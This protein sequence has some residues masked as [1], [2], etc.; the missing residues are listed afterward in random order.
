MRFL[1]TPA[2]RWK[3]WQN[4]NF[5]FYFPPY[6]RKPP[7]ISQIKAHVQSLLA[8]CHW[9]YISVCIRQSKLLSLARTP[10][11]TLGTMGA[12]RQ[13]NQ[14]TFYLLGCFNR[15]RQL[16]QRAF[17]SL[18]SWN[19]TSLWSGCHAFKWAPLP[20]EEAHKGLVVKTFIGSFCLSKKMKHIWKTQTKKWNVC[21][22]VSLFNWR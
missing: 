9:L 13:K 6:L 21:H 4:S 11:K 14:S 2:T 20:R 5:P 22:V 15:D 1:L 17:C 7:K 10:Q 19:Y 18:T 3:W 16:H 8:L 12:H